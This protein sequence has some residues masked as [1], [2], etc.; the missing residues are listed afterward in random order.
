MRTLKLI[1]LLGIFCKILF[2][3]AVTSCY[4]V[5]VLNADADLSA[6][7]RCATLGATVA[8]TSLLLTALN[9][10][11]PIHA[12]DDHY[13]HKIVLVTPQSQNVHK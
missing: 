8:E 6:A 2:T 13:T 1:T 4:Q 9:S 3:S 12:A 10:S 7:L 11:H 5:N